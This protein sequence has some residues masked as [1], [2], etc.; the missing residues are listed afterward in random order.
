MFKFLLL[1]FFLFT[2]QVAYTQAPGF[3]GKK[4]MVI[5]D[6]N[7]KSATLNPNS[8]FEA[9]SFSRRANITHNLIA[10]HFRPE[11]KISHMFK[12]D[13][14]AGI[15]LSKFGY[16]S[17]FAIKNYTH[18]KSSTYTYNPPMIY[19]PSVVKGYS[20]GISLK[21]HN[22]LNKGLVPPLGGYINIDLNM[23]VFNSYLYADQSQQL[24]TNNFNIPTISLGI[25]KNMIFLSKIMM[26]YGVSI[27]IPFL[28]VA[29]W[30]EDINGTREDAQT[31]SQYGVYDGILAY[32]LINF[33]LGIGLI[34][35]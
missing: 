28:P 35:F 34:P 16:G 15:Q 24:F 19:V 22:P 7:P 4:T 13:F 8:K 17:N 18:I 30:K 11:I 9:V 26:Q 5:F 21:W 2:I 29:Y 32:S 3:L 31:A 27:G 12:E 25:G 20:Y 6:L 1:P 33:N 23:F 14:S 10:M